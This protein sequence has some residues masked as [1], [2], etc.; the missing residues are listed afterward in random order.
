MEI[1]LY[2]IEL[3]KFLKENKNMKFIDEVFIEV[4]AGKGGNGIISFRREKFIPKGGPDGGNGGNGGSIFAISDHNINTLIDLRYSHFYKAKN[5]KNGQGAQK[6]GAS[7]ESIK[8]RV[9]V[10]TIIYDFET[11]RILSDLVSNNMQVT[12]ASGGKGGYGNL[13]F[14]SSIRRAP[15]LSTPGQFGERRKFK[16]EL[17]VLADVG[18]FGLPNVGKS[19][20]LSKISN[21]KP[22]IADYPFTTLCPNLGVVNISLKDSFTVADV[23]GL[24]QGASSGAGLGH[25]F[26]R[27]LNR[28]KILLHIVDI[29]EIYRMNQA[30]E[31]N[32]L[33]I[34]ELSQYDPDLSD[35]PRW[36]VLNKIDLI[37]TCTANRIREYFCRKTMWNTP[38]FLISNS[39]GSGL[40]ELVLAL[41]SHF[42]LQ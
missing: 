35:K 3:T 15:R 24:V 4:E 7:A 18:L 20:L 23:P 29:Y 10:G 9:P 32:F 2:A 16:M 6:N 25:L 1:L 14:K 26:L 31:D 38:V 5:G 19:S 42:K 33:I 11:K 28:T 34:K 40:K 17:R 39:T 37:P 27:H 41:Q 21:A 36:I 8:I 12:L 30:I 22:K 13:Y